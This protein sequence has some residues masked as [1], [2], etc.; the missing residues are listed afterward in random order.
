MTDARPPAWIVPAEALDW[1]LDWTAAAPG[2]IIPFRIRTPLRQADTLP[3]D[4]YRPG[5]DAWLT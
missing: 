3:A 4:A 2:A 5:R 1:A